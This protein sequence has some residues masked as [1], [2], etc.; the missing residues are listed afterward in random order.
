[1]ADRW[2]KLYEKIEDSSIYH[3][4]ELVHLWIHLL[5]KASKFGNTF[6]WNDGEKKVKPGELVTGR[7]KLHLET[8]IS[9]SKIQRALKRFERCN[10]IE[11]QTCNKYRL[12]TI[13]NWDRYQSSE[14]Q[15]NNKRTCN[16]QVT[17]KERTGNEHNQ[18]RKKERKEKEE[19]NKPDSVTDQTWKDFLTHRKN[20]KAPL[21]GRA[22]TGIENQAKK[23][24]WNLEDT[25]IECLNRGWTGFKS[26]WVNK[27]GSSDEYDPTQIQH[28]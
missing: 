11:Q 19:I 21:T 7:K 25:L 10:M 14:Q 15:T 12:I 22:L 28:N 13:L 20:K 4:S 17:N 27:S 26:E 8:G 5:I 3:D 16:E 24:G 6:P 23:A 1:M 2:V 18:E 9:E